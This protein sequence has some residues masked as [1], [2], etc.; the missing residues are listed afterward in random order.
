M[1]DNDH[2]GNPRPVLPD[3]ALRPHF[4]IIGQWDR[5]HCGLKLGHD[6]PGKADGRPHPRQARE[7]VPA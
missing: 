5:C 1:T 2:N 4:P 7:L 6:W 3:R